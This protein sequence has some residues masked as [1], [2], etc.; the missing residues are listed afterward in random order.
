MNKCFSCDKGKQK[1]A[2]GLCEKCHQKAIRSNVIEKLLGHCG[3]MISGSKSGYGKRFPNN[4]AIFNANICTRKDGKI[5]FG[6]IDITKDEGKLKKLAD[7][8]HCDV[9]ILYE[10]D[11]RFNN[12]R[13]PLFDKFV[14]MVTPSG[15]GVVGRGLEDYFTRKGAKLVRTE[16]KQ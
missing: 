5:W 6:D 3:K 9:Y 7:E 12:E 1:Y 4:F 2:S 11:A 14:Y 16:P 15:K 8:L 10:M 13:T